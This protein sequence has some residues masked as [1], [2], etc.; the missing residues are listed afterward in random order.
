[1]HHGEKKPAKGDQ[2]GNKKQDKLRRMSVLGPTAS[3][4]LAMRDDKGNVIDD[5]KEL[6]WHEGFMIKQ[7]G[8]LKKSDLWQERCR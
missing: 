3:A 7:S 5:K 6:Y 8:N 4:A 2:G 1:M